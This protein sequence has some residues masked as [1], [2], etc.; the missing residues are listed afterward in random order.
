MNFAQ[1][2]EI[3]MPGNAGYVNELTANYC[4][5]GLGHT[6]PGAN[7][8]VLCMV[9]HLTCRGMCSWIVKNLKTPF[10]VRHGNV[11]TVIIVR[12]FGLWC[13]RDVYLCVN[14]SPDYSQCEWH[15]EYVYM[16]SA[17]RQRDQCVSVILQ[18]NRIRG[19]ATIFIICTFVYCRRRKSE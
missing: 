3:T 7:W 14:G 6:I 17:E 2:Q 16:R 9:L 8:C 10:I 1:I 13:V 12:H 11:L 15:G 5:K 18:C 19:I 4:C